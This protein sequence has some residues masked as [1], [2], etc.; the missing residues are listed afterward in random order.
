MDVYDFPNPTQYPEFEPV[1]YLTNRSIR[2]YSR[3]RLI[4]LEIGRDSVLSYNEL[5]DMSTQ[6]GVRIPWLAEQ[7]TR[8][9]FTSVTDE[10]V[11]IL[12]ELNQTDIGRVADEPTVHDF[13]VTRLNNLANQPA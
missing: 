10:I 11:T 12:A 13:L 9:E 3:T 4:R 8:P 7:L 1:I 6:L 2:A 5:L